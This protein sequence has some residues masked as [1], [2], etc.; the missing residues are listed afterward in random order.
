MTFSDTM[1][2]LKDAVYKIAFETT[3]FN[4]GLKVKDLRFHVILD[5]DNTTFTITINADN[6]WPTKSYSYCF[7]PD[8]FLHYNNLVQFAYT[9]RTTITEYIKL[10]LKERT[11]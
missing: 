1:D 9:I 6:N 3:K 5:R 11:T 10:N 4:I 8:H 2:A 7:P